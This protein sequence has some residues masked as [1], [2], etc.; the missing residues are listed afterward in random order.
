VPWV[1]YTSPE[2]A[3]VGKTEQ[4]LKAEGVDYRAV[5]FPS[6][7]NGRARAMGETPVRQDPRRSQADR[8]LGMHVIGPWLRRL[9]PK[10][11]SRW[12]SARRSEDLARIC[13]RPHPSAV[14]S[15]PAKRRSAVDGGT[16][17]SLI[18]DRGLSGGL[19]SRATLR[20]RHDALS[21]GSSR[22]LRP[23]ARHSNHSP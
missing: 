18:G 9:I 1:I 8:I 14:G 5:A 11:S 21:T 13:H 15:K 2:I 20:P 19:A 6:L 12:N 17:Q 16:A 7:A 10:A 3:W 4:Q 22:C 23:A